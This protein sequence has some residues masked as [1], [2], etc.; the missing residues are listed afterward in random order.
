MSLNK[1]GTD[2]YLLVNHNGQ[3]FEQKKVQRYQLFYKMLYLYL[4]QLK[5]CS[6][7]LERVFEFPK[8]P[9][10]FP[11]VQTPDTYFVPSMQSSMVGRSDNLSLLSHSLSTVTLIPSLSVITHTDLIG[12]TLSTSPNIILLVRLV[13]LAAQL[14]TRCSIADR[15]Q[16]S[17]TQLLVVSGRCLQIR[18]LK[19]CLNLPLNTVS[20]AWGHIQLHKDCKLALTP[21]PQQLEVN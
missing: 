17:H 8:R 9:E 13:F 14:S 15:M 16:A 21:R 11:R 7:G 3:S 6:Y 10:K 2:E 1:P 12:Q 18:T 20:L 19:N 5:E 4:P